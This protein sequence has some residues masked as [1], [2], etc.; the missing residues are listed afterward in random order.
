MLKRL[1]LHITG[2]KKRSEERAALFSVRVHVIVMA[3]LTQLPRNI[4]PIAVMFFKFLI[5]KNFILFSLYY[6]L[7]IFV[8]RIPNYE[9]SKTVLQ[10][11]II[12]FQ[13]AT[14]W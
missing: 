6:C 1:T 13:P 14:L 9:F 5:K 10:W 4:N 11:P 8:V 7:S 3:L 12:I 2:S